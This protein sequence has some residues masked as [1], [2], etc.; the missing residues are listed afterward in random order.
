M[1]QE[2]STT[3]V[4]TLD[5]CAASGLVLHDDVLHVVADD[6]ALL[7]RYSLQGKPLPPLP[8]FAGDPPPPADYAARKKRKPD[9]EALALLPGGSLLALGSGSK[10]KRQRGCRLDLQDGT[11]TV[12]DLRPLYEAL[13]REIPALNIEGAVLHGDTLVLAQRGNSRT[14]LQALVVLDAT[15]ALHDLAQGRLTARGLRRIQPVAP[16]QLAG[17]PLGLT[18]LALHPDGR[19]WFTAAAEDTD[20]PV[21]DGACAGSVIGCFSADGQVA[22]SAPLPPGLK[23]EGLQFQR[24]TAAGDHWWLVA[25]ADSAET[26]APLLSVVLPGSGE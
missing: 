1:T 25:D 18:D 8:L 6:S 2:L 15:T 13:G 9:L 7:H 16:G 23:V 5:I 4:A 19:L 20:N 12:I 17:I 22:W 10:E 26:R 11:A 24:R 14:A 3:L 21:D